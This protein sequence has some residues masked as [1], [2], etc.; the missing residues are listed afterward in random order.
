MK[1]LRDWSEGHEV[2]LKVQ[3]GEETRTIT[4]KLGIHPRRLLE[5]PDTS[6]GMMRVKSEWDLAYGEH[7]RQK[8]NLF[9]PKTDTKFPVMLWIHA[10]A[11]SFG[12][13]EN[14]TALAMRF[15]ERGIGFAPMS[16][17]LSSK[18]WNDPKASKEGVK[19]P[20]HA[21]DV[22]AAFAW[23]RKR[24]PGHPLF[25]GGHSCGAHLSALLAVDPRYLKKHGLGI[26]EIK[27]V[28]AP[29]GGYDLV[30]YHDILANG[31]EGEGGLGKEFADAHL[32]WIFGDTKEDW[33]AASPTTYLKGCK[34]P[35]LI[36][37]EAPMG[38]RCYTLDFEE[39]VKKSDVKSIRFL[40][41]DDRDH[42][43]TT[44]MMS[45]KEEDPLRK[46]A[47]AFIREHAG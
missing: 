29:G 35:M 38:V 30:R 4:V 2:K 47:I 3:R 11:W 31:V 19:H 34:T 7:E 40:Y 27:G 6:E 39:T 41:M 18:V 15:A 46:A 44:P 28:F 8:L 14:E 33:I 12:G 10:G 37:G 26:E 22:A 13:R 16:Y 17:R 1:I 5:Q 43:Q 24:F 42:G 21:H 36:V 25:L 20:A 9:T 32:K 23:I 45:R